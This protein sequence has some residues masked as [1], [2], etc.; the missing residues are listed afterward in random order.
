[1]SLKKSEPQRRI[2]Q[3][4][5]LENAQGCSLNQITGRQIFKSGSYIAVCYIFQIQLMN[6]IY[7]NHNFIS[8]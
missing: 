3:N 7:S 6:L 2:L 4:I 5:V 8:T 1:M